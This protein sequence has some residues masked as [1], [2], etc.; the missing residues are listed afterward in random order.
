MRTITKKA[1]ATAKT[2]KHIVSY[3]CQLAKHGITIDEIV[4]GKANRVFIIE[5][6]DD[7]IQIFWQNHNETE[8]IFDLENNLDLVHDYAMM[9]EDKWLEVEP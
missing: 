4:N 8:M 6:S 9:N 1:P 3:E 7:D 2:V 5:C